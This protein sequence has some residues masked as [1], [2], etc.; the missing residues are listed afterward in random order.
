VTAV[1]GGAPVVTG[2]TTGVLTGEPLL[3]RG[4]RQLSIGVAVAA[5]IYGF[6]RVLGTVVADPPGHWSPFQALSAGS[7]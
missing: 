2:A 3:R 1:V 5:M 6:G 7:R 4:L